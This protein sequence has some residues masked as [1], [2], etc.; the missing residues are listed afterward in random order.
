MNSILVTNETPSVSYPNKSSSE[1]IESK[2]PK[3]DKTT[4][5]PSIIEDDEPDTTEAG[6]G[7]STKEKPKEPTPETTENKGPGEE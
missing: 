5:S 6:P 7:V 4:S 2:A 1:T 3:P